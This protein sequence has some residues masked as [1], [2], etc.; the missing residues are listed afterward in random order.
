[1]GSKQNKMNSKKLTENGL[2]QVIFGSGYNFRSTTAEE[3]SLKDNYLQLVEAADTALSSVYSA[4][5]V[6]G[7]R[8]AYVDGSQG[9]NFL[10][11]KT[12]PN[13]DG[14]ITD[15]VGVGLIIKY[16]D[17]TPVIIYD[18]VKK[19]QASV[20]SGWRGTVQ[21]IAVKAIKTMVTDFECR[22]SNL[23]IYLGPSIDMDHYEVGP[24]VYEAFADFSNRD[25]FFKKKA[26]KYLLS[27]IDAIYQKLLD[28]GVQ[29][30]QIEQSSV[31][32]YTDE[33]LHSARQQGADYSLN[34]ILTVM[35]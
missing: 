25:A 19:V 9:E 8:I 4:T 12:I 13:A 31:S 33:R 2:T 20:H 22:L 16:A 34:A 27:N 11:G 18:P 30:S 1:M 14:L 23:L 32:T 5:Q 6:H 28:S 15:Q 10:V 21:Q 7:N 3:E 24:E 17:C 35:T 26:D 29:A